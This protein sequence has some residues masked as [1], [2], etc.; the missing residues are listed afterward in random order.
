M[1]DPSALPRRAAAVV[2]LAALALC[3]TGSPAFALTEPIDA[4]LSPAASPSPSASPPPAPVPLP[5][6]LAP[7]V[8]PVLETVANLLPAEEPVSG[9][10]GQGGTGGAASA[11]R[12]SPRL[13]AQSSAPGSG[14]AALGS[15]GGV[16]ALAAGAGSAALP[17]LGSPVIAA[18]PAFELPG[19]AEPLTAPVTEVAAGRPAGGPAAPAGLPALVVAVAAVAVVAAGAGHV[20]E[21]RV[22][23]AAPGTE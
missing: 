15:L 14:S 4:V 21:V 10:G 11:P 18:A 17:P 1:P 8:D 23:R 2:G 9:Q 20:A 7:V 12:P 6:P 16:P 13:A 3:L 22:R 5:A 19:L